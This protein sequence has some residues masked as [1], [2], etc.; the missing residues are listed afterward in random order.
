MT[1]DSLQGCSTCQS[2]TKNRTPSRNPSEDIKQTF[3]DIHLLLLIFYFSNLQSFLLYKFY[4]TIKF[5]FKMMIFNA[6]TDWELPKQI[7]V[8][9]NLTW[10]SHTGSNH[11]ILHILGKVTARD[12]DYLQINDIQYSINESWVL[13]SEN[14]S[15]SQISSWC[16]IHHKDVFT[17]QMYNRCRLSCNLRVFLLLTK[18]S[19]SV[20]FHVPISWSSLV[21][22]SK[23]E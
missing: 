20:M 13:E 15:K 5:C 9:F 23:L 18:L 6:I 17:K 22:A 2:S 19:L 12:K 3:V 10:Q 11:Y 8:D 14:V 21:L 16:F 4:Y 7:I 1:P